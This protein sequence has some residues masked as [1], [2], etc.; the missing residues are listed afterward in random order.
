MKKIALS[1]LTLLVSLCSEEPLLENVPKIIDSWDSNESY[2]YLDI[3]LDAGLTFS[4]NY[5]IFQLKKNGYGAEIHF[6]PLGNNFFLTKDGY[7]HSLKDVTFTIYLFYDQNKHLVHY[8]ILKEFVYE[9]SGWFSS[10][11]ITKQMI[12]I[13]KIPNIDIDISEEPQF[14]FDWQSTNKGWFTFKKMK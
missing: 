5:S 7:H 9:T 1:F 13:D 10:G 4:D 3:E 14:N 2:L 12:S 6:L 8:K 11:T